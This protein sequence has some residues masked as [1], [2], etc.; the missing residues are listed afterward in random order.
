MER[1]ARHGHV[2]RAR[3]LGEG[4]V[5]GQLVRAQQ[6]QRQQQQDVQQ[7]EDAAEPEQEAAQLTWPEL[8]DARW[9]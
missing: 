4:S 7:Q 6:Q 3:L 2:D 1:R 5:L 9:D 8:W